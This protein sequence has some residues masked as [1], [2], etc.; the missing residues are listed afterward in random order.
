MDR[1]CCLPTPVGQIQGTGKY[2]K[3]QHS[4]GLFCQV[5]VSSLSPNRS[6]GAVSN[7]QRLK[8]LVVPEML[9]TSESFLILRQGKQDTKL[10]Q[11]T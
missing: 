7:T 6:P 4:L 1:L 9:L 10:G 11:W 8:E 3:L 2:H 5:Q